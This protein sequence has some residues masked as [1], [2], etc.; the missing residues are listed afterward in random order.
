[1]FTGTL[2]TFTTQSQVTPTLSQLPTNAL[3]C[4]TLSNTTVEI[5]FMIESRFDE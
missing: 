2:P 3:V 4:V 1:M 5:V